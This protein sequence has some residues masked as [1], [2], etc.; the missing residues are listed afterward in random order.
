MSK[1]MSDLVG[2]FDDRGNFT[3]VVCL[4]DEVAEALLDGDDNENTVILASDGW[5]HE[6]GDCVKCGTPCVEVIP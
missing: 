5:R 4:G 6:V 3:C 2:I 1:Q